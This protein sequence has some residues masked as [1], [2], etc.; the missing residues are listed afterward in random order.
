MI[1][2]LLPFLLCFASITILA[3]NDFTIELYHVEIDIAEDGTIQVTETLD[4][5]YRKKMRGIYRDIETKGKF[6]NHVQHLELSNIEVDNYKFKVERKSNKYRIRIGDANKYI[7]GKHQYV[8][9]YTAKNGILN[10]ETHEEFYWNVISPEWKQKIIN[11]SFNITLPKSIQLSDSDLNLFAGFDK[12][13]SSYGKIAQQGNTIIGSSL[14]E[15]GKGKGMSTSFRVPKGYFFESAFSSPQEKTETPFAQKPKDFSYPIPLMILASL[16][17]GFLKWGRNKTEYQAQEIYY[18]PNDMTP[19]EVGTF[20]DNTVNN[21]DVISLIP[22]W[23]HQGKI[24]IIALDE[25]T[26][27]D[28]ALQKIEELEANSPEYQKYFFDELFSDADTVFIE[29]LKHQFYKQYAKVKSMIKKEALDPPYY[30]QGAIQLFHSWPILIF[31]LIALILGALSM[32]KYKLVFTG[33][34]FCVL[35]L[36]A[37]VIRFLPPRKS[38]EGIALK[39]QLRSFKE[40]IENSDVQALDSILQK[41][42]K[43]FEKVFP[44]AVAYGIDKGFTNKFDALS[45]SAPDWYYYESGRTASHKDFQKDVSIEKMGKTISIPP[46]ADKDSSSFSP[47]GG[48]VGG[49]FGGGGGGGW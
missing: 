36:V 29:D 3:N 9:H 8:I 4:V 16:I 15:L 34:S 11:A 28:I 38:A 18:P 41:D 14:V 6:L 37:F 46:V 1:K 20:Y 44:Y 5:N 27:S 19:A 23:G 43:Y 47:G 48:S 26:N 17:L 42:Q 45:V 33:I 35:G 40:S 24:K 22:Y 7:K 32:A 13:D 30:D 12:E 2:F 21:R 31:S 39:H 25:Q 49:G 10:F